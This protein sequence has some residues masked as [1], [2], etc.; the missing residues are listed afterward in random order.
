M[1][2]DL[3]HELRRVARVLEDAAPA[4][5]LDELRPPASTGSDHDLLAGQRSSRLRAGVAWSVA[6]AAVAAVVIG[7]AV[8]AGHRRGTVDSHGQR[9]TG[10]VGQR[11]SDSGG[12]ERRH[13]GR[14][15]HAGVD[16]SGVIV[17]RD[18]DVASR[19]GR[20]RRGDADPAGGGG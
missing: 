11:Q 8:T 12:G 6:A 14:V 3:E 15:D 7:V 1:T 17:D 20:G 2:V 18:R 10:T 19:P 16:G 5:S 4:I 9:P 13:A